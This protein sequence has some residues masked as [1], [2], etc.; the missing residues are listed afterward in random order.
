MA[1][2]LKKKQI[3]ADMEI[4]GVHFTCKEM[5]SLSVAGKRRHRCNEACIKKKLKIALTQLRYF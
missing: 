2:R 4:P 3:L 1:K 5:V